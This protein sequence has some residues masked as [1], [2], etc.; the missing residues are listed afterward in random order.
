M[1]ES[2][3]YSV[4][5]QFAGKAP[6]VRAIYERLL[7]E[8]RNLGPVGEEAKK[9]SIHLVRRTGFAGVHTR[10]ACLILNLRMEA[11][12]ASPRVVKTEQVSKN[13]FH[14]EIKLQSPDEVDVELIGW[15]AE[16]YRLGA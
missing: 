9:T 1:T 7:G 16:A 2:S 12:L 11:P 6:A 13:R 8:L 10:K 5:E 14:N 4:D 3:T 15:L